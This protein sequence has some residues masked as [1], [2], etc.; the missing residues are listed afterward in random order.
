MRRP[1][2]TSWPRGSET[3]LDVALKNADLVARTFG[4]GPGQRQGFPGH[5]EIELALVKLYRLTGKTDYLDLAK[6]F[7]D[8]RGEGLTLTAVSA[9]QPLRHLQRRDP[10]PGPQAGARAGRGRRPRRPADLHGS[11]GWPMSRRSTGDEAYL[12]AVR[13]LWENVVGRKMYLTGG[14]GSRHDRERF[15]EAY[16]LPNL[17]GY[18]ETCAS[19][20]MAFW[21]HRMFLLTG[22]AAYLDVM[23]RVM[24]QR[25][26]LRRVARRDAFLLSQ[27]A[28]SGREVPVQQGPGGAGAVVRRGLLPG[29]RQPVP[30][31]RAGLRLCD[32]GRHSLCEL[33]RRGRSEGRA[34]RRRPSPSGRRPAI[35]GTG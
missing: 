11:R 10:D 12:E 7:L 23:E 15:G 1:R 35:P 34:G 33:V 27:S 4:R 25:R 8:Q 20:G 31:V 22:D 19:I 32:E 9:R 24:L 6:Y 3:L 21:N 28:R 5:Q 26:H 13:R 2:P 30:A 16:E 29:Q 17:T 18:L 14:I